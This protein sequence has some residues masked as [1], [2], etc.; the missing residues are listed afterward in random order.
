[1]ITSF[2]AQPVSQFIEPSSS[3]QPEALPSLEETSTES[4]RA[5]ALV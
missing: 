4:A 5:G 2:Q 1:M 3:I